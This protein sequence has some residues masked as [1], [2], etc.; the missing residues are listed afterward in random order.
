[1]TRAQ[2]DGRSVYLDQFAYIR[3]AKAGLGRGSSDDVGLLQHL[4]QRVMAG[5]VRFP[6]SAVHYL[7]TWR[8]GNPTRRRELAA[9]MIRLSRLITMAP[10]HKLWQHEVLSA[11][12]RVFQAPLPHSPIA[13][14]GRGAAHAFGYD[15]FAPPAQ[16]VRQGDESLFEMLLLAGDGTDPQ[17]FVAE[18]KA[19]HDQQQRF[20]EQHTATARR[21]LQWSASPD[22]QRQR[23]RI[24]A[25][26]DFESDLAPALIGAGV[27]PERLE[28]LGA[29]GLERLVEAIPTLWALTELRRLRFA[30]PAQG[31]SP[32]DLY[33][34]RAL[35][36]AIVYCD[37]VVADK[38]WCDAIRRTDL[39]GGFNT[40]VINDIAQIEDLLPP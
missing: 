34:L 31:F 22:E 37:I 35:S 38:A 33:D 5:S 40:T 18:E 32:H 36:C 15:A 19:R 8:Q 23:I 10:T 30:N 1:M 27:T 26:T 4:L 24:Q 17:R 25:L 9:E 13:V 21:I 28:S 20:A 29:A 3:L 14:W 6:L 2:S 39:G 16:A 12:H 11:L 7:E